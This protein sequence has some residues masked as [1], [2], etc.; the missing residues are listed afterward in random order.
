MNEV[1]RHNLIIEVTEAGLRLDQA[2]AA[3]LP[4]YSR[5]N[6][7]DWISAGRVRLNDKNCRPRDMV[8]AGDTVEINAQFA[9]D[10]TLSGEPVNFD[11]TYSDD[12]CLIVDKPAGLVV[13]PGAGNPNETLAN[14]L[15]YRYPELAELPRAGLIHRLDKDTSGLLIVARNSWSYQALA[16]MMAAREITREY[17]AL[18]IGELISGA[19]IDAPMGRDPNNRTRMKVRNDG[20]SAVTHFRIAHKYRG[21]TQLRVSLETGRT[22]QIRVHLSHIGHPLVGDIKYG[23]RVLLPREPHPDLDAQMRNFKRPALHARRL[24]F[25]HPRDGEPLSFESTLATDFSR[26][27]VACQSDFDAAAKR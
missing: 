23:A 15:I 1:R 8:H 2:L 17:A 19:T 25:K 11:V 16:R 22:H 4:Q 5:T 9:V 7:K 27:L 24:A 10:T 21:C 26:L 20:R 12:D 3:R 13:H 18:A 6:I 14:G